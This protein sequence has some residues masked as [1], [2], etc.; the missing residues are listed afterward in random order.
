M[1]VEVDEVLLEKEISSAEL[2]RGLEMWWCSEK[3]SWEY[4]RLSISGLI[5]YTKYF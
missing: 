1:V 5:E 2:E 4:G 3:S